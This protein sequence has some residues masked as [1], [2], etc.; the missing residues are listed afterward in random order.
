MFAIVLFT[1]VSSLSS[2]LGVAVNPYI[3]DTKLSKSTVCHFIITTGANFI[4]LYKRG[5]ITHICSP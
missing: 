4:V 5:I 3:I 1:Y 2:A